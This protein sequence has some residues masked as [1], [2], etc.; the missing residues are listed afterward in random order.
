MSATHDHDGLPFGLTLYDGAL[1][2]RWAWAGITTWGWAARILTT[3]HS[4]GGPAPEPRSDGKKPEDRAKVGCPCWSAATWFDGW[5]SRKAAGVAHVWALTLDY[6]EGVGPVKALDRWHGYER[7]VYTS[8]SHRPDKPKCRIVLPLAEPVPGSVWSGVYRKIL[9]DEGG[10]ADRQ[11]IDPSRIW[12]GYAIGH[13]GPH[14][15]RRRSGA[16]MSLL[17]LALRVEDEQI[18]AATKAEQD[19]ARI[20]QIAAKA[21]QQAESMRGRGENAAGRVR[22]RLYATDPDLRTR[23]GLAAGGKVV[24]GSDG[25]R[26]IRKAKCPACGRQSVWFGIEKGRARCDHVNSCGFGLDGGVKIIEYADGI[27]FYEGVL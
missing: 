19:R 11:V 5:T 24:A 7:L 27:G 2:P 8:W 14:Y 15:A 1:T 17:D 25:S 18:A 3:Q 22:A 16:L 26:A 23:V 13:G 6:D 9:Q 12:F 4:A 20:A 10:Q 21:R